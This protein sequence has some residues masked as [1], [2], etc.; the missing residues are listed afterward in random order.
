VTKSSAKCSAYLQNYFG[1]APPRI[2]L[3]R[4]FSLPISYYKLHA[5]K[6]KKT[7]IYQANKTQQHSLTHIKH[8]IRTGLLTANAQKS[9]C[10]QVPTK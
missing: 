10:S 2:R 9:Y 4:Y 8:Y 6:K 1:N 3:P 5:Q 7:N